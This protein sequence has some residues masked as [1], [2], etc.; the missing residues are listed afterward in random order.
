[1][2][3]IVIMKNFNTNTC[4]CRLDLSIS[5]KA[6]STKLVIRLFIQAG[7]DKSNHLDTFYN[8]QRGRT[9]HDHTV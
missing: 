5:S 9:A 4:L 8:M 7:S 3:I 6:D 1:M 2:P